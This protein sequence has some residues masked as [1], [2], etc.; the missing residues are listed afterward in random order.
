MLLRHLDVLNNNDMTNI[1]VRYNVATLAYL[2]GVDE[3]EDFIVNT[4]AFAHADV[5]MVYVPEDLDEKQAAIRSAL[6][7]QISLRSNEIIHD[8]Y[9][10]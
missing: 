9:L 3:L 5:N 1:S 10:V 2:D 7:W 4:T 6:E 8:F